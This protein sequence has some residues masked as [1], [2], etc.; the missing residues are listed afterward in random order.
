[1]S[2]EERCRALGLEIPA[3]PPP[4]AAYVP[5]VRAGQLLFTSG[6]LPVAGGEVVFRGRIGA[7]LSPADGYE[8]ARLCALNCLGVIRSVAGSLEQVEQ[9]VQITGY[10]RSAPGFEGQPGVVN[11][12]SELVLAVFGEAGRH[13]RAALGVAE[14]PLGAAV[15]LTMVVKL[16]DDRRR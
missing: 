10:V 12:A 6:Q 14:L 2:V 13:A 1:M 7:E 16:Q 3:A 4:V 5:G 11:G 8:A 15:E 9:V